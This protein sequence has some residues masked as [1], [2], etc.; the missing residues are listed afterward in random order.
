MWK[1][2]TI[3]S[4]NHDATQLYKHFKIQYLN[5]K[6]FLNTLTQLHAICL[7]IYESHLIHLQ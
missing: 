2:K 4:E 3:C 6:T 5:F 7:Q 1:M